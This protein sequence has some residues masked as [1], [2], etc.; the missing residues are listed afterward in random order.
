MM[1][2]P[3]SRGPWGQP[4]EPKQV[5]LQLEKLGKAQAR[6]TY[7]RHGYAEPLYGVSFADLG[8]L[9]KR[10]KTNH[11]LAEGLWKSGN[12]DARILATMV[13]DPTKLTEAQADRWAKEANFRTLR[14]YLGCLA[15]ESPL[16]LPLAAK[17]NAADDPALRQ[18]SGAIVA[19]MN[20]EGRDVPVS[21]QKAM[22]KRIERDIHTADNWSR[23]GMMYSLIG[24]GAYCPALTGE[25]IAAAK[26]IGKVE[27]DP[28]ETDCKMPD[29]IPYIEK[30][31]AHNKRRK[32]S[33]G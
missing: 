16:A 12:A 15:G 5:L 6:K 25:V 9:K 21:L 20:R 13:A 23:Y 18:L 8:A 2:P 22:L 33:G 19:Y 3:R 29:P 17:W 26:R 7:L 4:V 27:F 24:I 1:A 30:T 10:I 28:G 11:S 14:D 31:I 32:A